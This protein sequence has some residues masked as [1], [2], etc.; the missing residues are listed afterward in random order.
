MERDRVRIEYGDGELRR[1]AEDP[2]C[3]SRRWGRDVVVAYRKKIQILRAAHDEGD[4]RALRGLRLEHLTATRAGT[5]SIRINDQCR[6]VLTSRPQTDGRVV[7]VRE[8]VDYHWKDAS[9]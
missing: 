4:L 9:Q 5:V 8:L 7:V 2:D 1:L 3:R 6:L